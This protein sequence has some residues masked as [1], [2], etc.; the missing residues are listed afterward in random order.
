MARSTVL[1]RRRTLERRS[2][3]LKLNRRPV[4]PLLETL[5]RRDLLAS[6]TALED[7]PLLVS[8]PALVHAVV[9]A[10]P[11]HGTVSFSD[12]GGFTYKP[13]ENYNG[14][15]AFVYGFANSASGT[16]LT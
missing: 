10:G 2:S 14:H 15:D 11:A 6:Y 13:A 16:T 9:I 8:D 12:A 7:T 4:R 1:F 3:Q 5:E